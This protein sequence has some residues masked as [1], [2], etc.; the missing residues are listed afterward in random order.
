[1]K[2]NRREDK[3]PT[4][5][6]S[7]HAYHYNREERLAMRGG[8]K[9]DEGG[10]F[11]RNKGLVIVLIDLVFL[12]IIAA[13]FFV[14]LRPDETSLS[15]DGYTFSIR[16]VEFGDELLITVR[17]TTTPRDAPDATDPVFRVI[18]PDGTTVTDVVPSEGA[19]T[20]VRRTIESFG[21]SV[22]SVEIEFR[23]DRLTPA[24]DILS[25]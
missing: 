4:Q 8:L 21:A 18:F 15:R 10:F 22:V 19:E 1:M 3:D 24:T 16:A 20:V 12:A 9:K 11:K 5:G 2:R 23:G 13:V 14:V 17:V 25:D 7:E 6:L